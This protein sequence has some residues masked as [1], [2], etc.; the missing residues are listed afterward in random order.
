M[1]QLGRANGKARRGS[2]ASGTCGH[3]PPALK[4]DVFTRWP[5]SRIHVATLAKRCALPLTSAQPRPR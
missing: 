1:R 4:R 5:L 3:A 2:R